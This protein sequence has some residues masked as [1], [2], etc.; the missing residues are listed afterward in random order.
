VDTQPAP[1]LTFAASAAGTYRAEVVLDGAPGDPPVP[2][3]IGNP[4]YLRPEGWGRDTPAAASPPTTS[5][6]IQG[7]PWHVEKD[8]G[9]T[10]SV[11]QPDHPAGPVTL[12]FGLAA[13]ER[14]GQYA[15]LGIS[16][17]RALSDAERIAFQAR[18]SRPMRVSVQARHPQSG[19]RW[20][21]SIYADTLPREIV[22]PLSD[23]RGVGSAGAF[24]PSSTDSLLFVVDTVNTRPGTSG[25]LTIGD[26]RVGR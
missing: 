11:A 21:R 23:F 22:V 24:E 20:Q 25:T 1:E 8:D 17:G 9:S 26:L 16:V 3:I 13:G 10:A 18:A 5:R 15:A 2:W 12:R 19:A 4:I 6:D 14:I 7:G